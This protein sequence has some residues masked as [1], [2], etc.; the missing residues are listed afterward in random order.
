[1]LFRSDYDIDRFT[2]LRPFQ[3]QE[4]DIRMDQPTVTFIW[5]DDR[6]W[7]EEGVRER[8][9]R[10]LHRLRGRPGLARD[11]LDDQ[12]QRVIT[13]AQALRHTFPQL[14]FAVAGPGRPGGL[15]EWILDL[16]T[17]K[18]NEQVER[19][20]CERYVQSHLVIGVHGSSM[21][22]PSAHSGAVIELVPDDRWGNLMQDILLKAKDGRELMSRCRFL[23]LITSPRIVCQ[24][25]ISLLRDLPATLLNFTRPWTDHKALQDDPQ[26]IIK[27]RREVKKRDEVALSQHRLS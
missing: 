24:V 8:L 9:Q 12:R 14:D 20:W 27:R 13:L 11:S 25:A 23:P 26:L 21:L 4:W 5:R 19:I 6:I 15:P 16:R 2:R 18:I 17:S 10:L 3:L 1:M 22:L 7:R